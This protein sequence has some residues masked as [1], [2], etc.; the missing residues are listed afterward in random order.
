M[1][2]PSPSGFDQP[3]L[4]DLFKVQYQEPSAGPA[5]TPNPRPSGSRPNHRTTIIVGCS[6]GG[7][8]CIT[9]VAGLG[10]CYWRQIRHRITGSE[11]SCQEMDNQERVLQEMDNQGNF[12][13]EMDV[14]EPFVREMGA[15]NICWE[16]P[17]E[18]NPV[19]MGSSTESPSS[20]HFRRS[21][22]P[23]DEKVPRIPCRE[24]NPG[25]SQRSFKEL[26]PLPVA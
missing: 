21:R 15:E 11:S 4:A 26:P 14:P 3:G 18:N 25:G 9:L 12:V 2:E 19:E 6:V 23:A 5:A 7:I 20:S 24:S 10:L 22:V 8:A 16:L 17:A 1:Y 13:Q